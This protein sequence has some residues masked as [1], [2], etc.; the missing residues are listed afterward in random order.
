M[1]VGDIKTP[2]LP[3]LGGVLLSS[4]DAGIRYAGRED[5]VLIELS[6]GS[7]V[8]GCFTRNLYKAAPVIVSQKHLAKAPA[9]YLLINSGNANACTGTQG[10]NDANNS[11]KQVAKLANLPSESVLPFSTGV[12][13][14]PMNMDAMEKGIPRAFKNLGEDNWESVAKA[15][16]TTDTFVKMVTKE[17]VI[18]GAKVRINGI[19]KGAGMIRPDMATML[20]YVFTDANVQK[21]TLQKICSLATDKSFNR[22][23]VDGDTSTNDSIILAAT[24]KAEMSLIDSVDSRQGQLLAESVI[25]VFQ[26][27]AQLLVRDGEGA[28]KFVTI[29]VDNG[30]NTDDCLK[31][32]YS[33]AHSPLVKTAMF[34]SDPNWGRLVAAIGRSGV[35]HLDV[36]NVRVWL[37][38]LLIVE[39][40]GVASG[41]R[42]ELGQQVFDKAEFTIRIDLGMGNCSETIWTC[43]LSHEY[44]S[45]NADYRT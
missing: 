3:P 38:D 22:V 40:A 20:A 23:T 42:E 17:I 37:N 1:A 9:R 35:E 14:M 18:D 39:R 44:V 27:L 16:M 5:L 45:I 31:V 11:C 8:A 25:D 24:G 7:S 29:D 30:A 21:Q 19:A 13:G 32:A 36:T 28:T 15:I 12:I 26:E 33:I 34:A 10:M 2:H 4:V 43:D 6:E 41:Y